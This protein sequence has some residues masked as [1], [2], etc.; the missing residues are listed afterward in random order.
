VLITDV[1]SFTSTHVIKQLQ[2]EGYQV[3]GLVS[4][5]Q[6]E[7]ARIK[8]L[9]E[10]CPDAKYKVEVIEADPSKTGSLESAIKEVQYVIHVI[11]P[12]AAQAATQEGEAPVQPAVDAV[13][14]VFKASVESKTVKR[15]ILSSSYQTISAVPTAA[16]DKVFTEADWADSESADPLVKSLILAEKA[17]WDFVKELPDADKIELC[18]LNPT[19]P[20]GPPLLDAQSDVVKMLLDRGITGC[21][22]VCYSLVDVR[23]V[24]AAHLKALELE[25]A[26]GNRHIIHGSN[27]W[28]KDIALILAKEF[29]PQGY[30]IHTMSL[31]NVCL[32]GLSLFN[33]NAKTFLPVVGKQS[34]FDNTRMKEVLG[35]E[36]RDVKETIVEEAKV[37]VER[38]L[39]KKPKR[40]RGQGA[41]AAADGEVKTDA[42]GEKKEG[43][44][45]EEK[46]EESPKENGDVSEGADKKDTA[47][48]GQGDTKTEETTDGSKPAAQEETQ[49]IE[50]AEAPECTW[51]HEKRK[52]VATIMGEKMSQEKRKCVANIMGE[53][54]V[55]T[56]KKKVCCHHHGR[57]ESV[58]VVTIVGEKKVCVLSLL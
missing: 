51:S 29:K 35:I 48:E 11:K 25:S 42:E 32:W 2:E 39:V 49:D 6:D 30:N 43:E 4:S 46:G 7:D 50:L 27:L 17:A 34:Q 55:V 26:A 18:V 41:S 19:L 14:N 21:P 36:P 12:V 54:S 40:V 38:G 45:K 13:Q 5:L 33:K 8:Q 52:C 53:K 28:M 3:R 24:A 20:L 9:Q 57:K 1:T 44:N 15:V 22:R 56:G 31:P 23:D 10:L 37:L 47:E 16:T 58:C